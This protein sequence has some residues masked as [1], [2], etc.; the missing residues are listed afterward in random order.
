[1]VEG[2]GQREQKI[3]GSYIE[4]KLRL[5]RWGTYLPQVRRYSQRKV[6]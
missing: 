3:P 5:R 4:P 6:R 2:Q 1:M